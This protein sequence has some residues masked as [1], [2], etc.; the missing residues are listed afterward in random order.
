MYLYV[1]PSRTYI[2]PFRG[3][4]FYSNLYNSFDSVYF[5]PLAFSS[6]SFGHSESHS[7]HS[8]LYAMHMKPPTHSYMSL[9]IVSCCWSHHDIE[10]VPSKL[11]HILSKISKKKKLH[12]HSIFPLQ[13]FSKIN[14]WQKWRRGKLI[15]VCR[16]VRQRLESIDIIGFVDVRAGLGSL[17]KCCP[18]GVNHLR[19]ANLDLR[20]NPQTSRTNNKT[21]LYEFC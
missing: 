14:G 10:I 9:A 1:R 12:I 6:S 3:R 4:I 13:H 19:F 20:I 18:C 16:K 11:S 2:W 15:R 8:I 21:G 17:D 7:A 5:H